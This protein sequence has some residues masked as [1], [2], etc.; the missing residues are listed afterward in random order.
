MK[1]NQWKPFGSNTDL[2]G[3]IIIITV[4]VILALTIG[5]LKLII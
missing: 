4:S 1:K 3:I 5:S 2:I